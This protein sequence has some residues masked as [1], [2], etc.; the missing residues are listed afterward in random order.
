MSATL[1][2]AIS[3]G[4]CGAGGAVNTLD[5][6]PVDGYFEAPNQ[7]VVLFMRHLWFSRN[8]MLLCLLTL[9]AGVQADLSFVVAG[10]IC[11]PVNVGKAIRT[12]QNFRGSILNNSEDESIAVSC[13]VIVESGT[14][15]VLLEV[16]AENSAEQTG[17]F[18]CVLRE[19]DIENKV[20]QTLRRSAQIEA[21][22][23]G[24]PFFGLLTMSL[25]DSRLNLTCLLPP[26]GSLGVIAYD[27]SLF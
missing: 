19:I 12:I 17:S 13:P 6:A 22:S 5:A 7:A 9:P 27:T 11:S 14:A 2:I 25:P 23:I 20:V 26:L 8:V 24:L 16:I 4:G 15:E 1:N 3:A 18:Q 10:D 21:N